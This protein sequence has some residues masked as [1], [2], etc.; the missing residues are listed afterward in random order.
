[1]FTQKAELNFWVN[2]VQQ[3][4]VQTYIGSKIHT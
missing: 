2:T 4:D 1:M 3:G